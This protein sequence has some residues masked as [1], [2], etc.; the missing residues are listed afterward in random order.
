LAAGPPEVVERLL[1]GWPVD[2]APLS[3]V[4]RLVPEQ[5]VRMLSAAGGAPLPDPV[6][7]SLH[8]H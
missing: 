7:R 4:G 8:F 2:L 6:P 1:D 3:I 5:G